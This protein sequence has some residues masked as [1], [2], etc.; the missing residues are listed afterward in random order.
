MAVENLKLPILYVVVRAIYI[1]QLQ[2]SSVDREVSPA[3]SASD[4]FGRL[5]KE[6]AKGMKALTSAV[7]E[8]EDGQAAGLV[9]LEGEPEVGEGPAGPGVGLGVD[10]DAVHGAPVL[11]HAEVADGALVD[12]PERGGGGHPQAVLLHDEARRRRAV[13]RRHDR[14]HRHHQQR[15]AAPPRPHRHGHQLLPGRPADRSIDR[16]ISNPYGYDGDEQCKIEVEE[17]EM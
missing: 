16:S 12:A 7:D 14:Q 4:H 10:D 17:I 5:L 11:R 6:G 2:I 1:I 9:G 15:A 8:Q 13:H 3:C